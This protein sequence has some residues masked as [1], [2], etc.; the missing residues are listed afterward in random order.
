MLRR[1][2]FDTDITQVLDPVRGAM[3]QVVSRGLHDAAEP[4]HR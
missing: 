4:D 3:L 1:L 2:P